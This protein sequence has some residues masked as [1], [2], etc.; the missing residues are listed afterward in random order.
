MVS[1]VRPRRSKQRR[2]HCANSRQ[3]S[4]GGLNRSIEHAIDLARH[5][6]IVLVQSFDL[7]SAQ[8]DGR[9]TPAETDVGVMPFG[10]GKLTDF[11]HKGECLPEIAESKRALDAVGVIA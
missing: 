4:G 11:L 8:G 6:K 5:D 10:L 2:E 7:L 1:G 3:G 9:A